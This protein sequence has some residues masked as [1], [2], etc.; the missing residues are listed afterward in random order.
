MYRAKFQ[1]LVFVMHMVVVAALGV[2][3]QVK[4]KPLTETKQLLKNMDRAHDENGSLKLLFE[5]YQ[6]RKSDLIKALYDTDQTISLNAQ[7][8][9]KY[10]AEP[11]SL[12]EVSKWIE[13]RKKTLDNYWLVPMDLVTK[14][15]Y[16]TA[17]D[18]ELTKLVLKSLYPNDKEYWAK[19]IAENTKLKTVLIEVVRGNIFTDGY[20]VVVRKENGRWRLLSNNLV[21]QS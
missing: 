2:E 13:Y 17:G 3:A 1:V 12:E 18:D 10:L 9:I 11:D 20:H 4:D 16:L 19:V 7:A 6:A 8:V 5:S 14:D 21:W 15:T